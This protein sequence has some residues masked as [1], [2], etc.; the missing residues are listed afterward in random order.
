[1]A[2]LITQLA[3]VRVHET[4]LRRVS[5]AEEFAVPHGSK[6]DDQRLQPHGFKSSDGV[7]A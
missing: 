3:Q 4:Y 1:M 5:C 6:T 7:S 2:G